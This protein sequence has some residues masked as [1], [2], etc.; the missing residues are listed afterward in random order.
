[1]KY[2]E[3]PFVRALNYNCSLMNVE[4]NMLSVHDK[5]LRIR[6][7]IHMDLTLDD[8]LVKP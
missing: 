7:I 2:A 3:E 5:S 6:D 8:I 4:Y 1:M